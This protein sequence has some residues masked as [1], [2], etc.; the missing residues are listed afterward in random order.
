MTN[1]EGKTVEPVTKFSLVA[2]LVAMAI[3]GAFEA[4]AALSQDANIPY[5]FGNTLT[6]STVAWAALWFGVVKKTGA[7]GGGRYW[8]ILFVTGVIAG[9]LMLAYQKTQVRVATAG[10]TDSYN[11]YARGE[12]TDSKPMA[13][14]EAGTLE[15]LTKT[16][17]NTFARDCSDYRAELAGA[18]LDDILSAAA[19]KSDP[20]LSASK[21]K[22]KR[23]REIIQ[24]YRTLY[25]ARLAAMG[26]MIDKTNLSE[27][28]KSKAKA[29]LATGV[30][31]GKERAATIWRLESESVDET[32]AAIDLLAQT[33]GTW[34]IA[35]DQINF[36]RP[37][38]I[39]AF[40]DH[41]TN[42]Q[43]IAAEEDAIYAQANVTAQT[44]LKELD[45][46]AK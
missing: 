26:D 23:G 37:A 33:R 16:L 36:D 29:G 22:V 45:A 6:V 35:G 5:I 43:R 10:I 1:S 19:L 12:Q 32:S 24:K 8:L 34:V 3:V 7:K 13:T 41:V 20:D 25:D 28:T 44:K 40:N 31:S 30:E 11:A 15:G 2:L 38:D 27:A 17:F 39:R 46:L 9:G 21:F 4:A 42:L 18:G 14:G